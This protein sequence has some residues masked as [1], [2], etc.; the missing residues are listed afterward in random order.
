ME[1]FDEL[2]SLARE[3]DKIL[4]EELAKAKIKPDTAEVRIGNIRTVGVMGDDRTYGHPAEI[5]LY[6]QGNF[7][8]DMEFVAPLSARI[9]NEVNGINRVVYVIGK[10]D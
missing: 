10:K 2:T 3:A 7:V 4:K 9:T 5:T 1:N 8:W 6:N